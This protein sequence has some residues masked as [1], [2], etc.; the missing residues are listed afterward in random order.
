ML[1][2][3]KSYKTI[4]CFLIF[5]FLISCEKLDQAGT[6]N[7]FKKCVDEI[8]TE[9][10]SENSIKSSCARRVQKEISSNNV[11]ENLNIYLSGS[12]GFNT[13]FSKSLINV[14]VTNE[15]GK[16]IITEFSVEAT[17]L[18]THD[19]DENLLNCTTDNYLEFDDGR[20]MNLDELEFVT[21]EE[22]QCKEKI[23]RETFYKWLEP[24]ASESYEFNTFYYPSKVIYQDDE[25]TGEKDNFDFRIIDIKGIEIIQK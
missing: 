20:I 24:N 17:Y 2:F 9:F 25:I 10:I 5:T 13:F 4:I 21:E 23:F 12:A 19:Q 7:A 8:K 22:D 14:N 11:D 1:D 3:F 15:S 6:M 18:V 16:Y